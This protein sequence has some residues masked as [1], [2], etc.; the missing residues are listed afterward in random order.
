MASSPLPSSAAGLSSHV[1]A[2]KAELYRAILQVFVAA[3]R[4]FRLH[5]R[6]DEV[7]VETAIVRGGRFSDRQQP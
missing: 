2:E 7:L 5:L 4:Q 6:P 1:S 3:K